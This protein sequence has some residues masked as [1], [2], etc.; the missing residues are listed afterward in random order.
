M[1]LCKYVGIK[2]CKYK[3][4]GTKSAIGLHAPYVSKG[5]LI[6]IA[7]VYMF[8]VDWLNK[9]LTRKTS[10]LWVFL[11]HTYVYTCNLLSF[12]LVIIIHWVS[13]CWL[14]CTSCSWNL[15]FNL[16]A[17]QGWFHGLW[18]TKWFIH[19]NNLSINIHTALL[20]CVHVIDDDHVPFFHSFLVLF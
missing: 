5:L 13:S 9:V 7:Q 14:V 10:N 4:K 15:S 2:Y 18:T 3:C 11:I 20:H 19:M 16:L 12:S 17:S 8:V 6:S 1:P